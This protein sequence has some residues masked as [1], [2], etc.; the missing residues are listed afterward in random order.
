[1][2]IFIIGFSGCYI[3]VSAYEER[4]VLFF[5]LVFSDIDMIEKVE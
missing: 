1:M 4:L 2:L 3:V 5:V